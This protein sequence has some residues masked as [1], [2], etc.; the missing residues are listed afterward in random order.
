M[1][2]ARRAEPAPNVS[3]GSCMQ[4]ADTAQPLASSLPRHAPRLTCCS[5]EPEML[6]ASNPNS[7]ATDR[8]LP[9]RC[10]VSCGWP[11]PKLSPE[12]CNAPHQ[13]AQPPAERCALHACCRSSWICSH[14][15]PCPIHRVPARQLALNVHYQCHR[16]LVCFQPEQ[17]MHHASL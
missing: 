16:W 15:E 3:L 8:Q 10:T 1:R 12:M 2:S 6:N 5:L 7:P 11:P 14:P 4:P 9:C 13:S 17:G